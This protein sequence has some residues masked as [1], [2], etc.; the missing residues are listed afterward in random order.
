MS[1]GTG[2]GTNVTAVGSGVVG[3]ISSLGKGLGD[4]GKARMYTKPSHLD[5]GSHPR[6]I[7]A[8]SRGVARRAGAWPSTCSGI[9][10]N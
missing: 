8:G 6:P 10:L 9:T 1:V 2:I 5:E 3:G 7:T 4:A